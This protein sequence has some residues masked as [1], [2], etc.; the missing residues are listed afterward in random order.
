MTEGGSMSRPFFFARP[1][2][3]ERVILIGPRV[4]ELY[5]NVTHSL[6]VPVPRLLWPG[7]MG[8]LRIAA[9]TERRS[10]RSATSAASTS[11]RSTT[12]PPIGGCASI[13]RAAKTPSPAIDARSFERSDRP[14]RHRLRSYSATF[15]YSKWFLIESFGQRLPVHFD[16]RIDEVV[17]RLALLAR[18]QLRG[19]GPS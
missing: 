10:I 6:V 9:W 11:S 12:L 19:R 4:A 1:R 14:T 8:Q 2:G 16:I 3:C 17:E 13:P 7:L 5:Q 18:S 15:A